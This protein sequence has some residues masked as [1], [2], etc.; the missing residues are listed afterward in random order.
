MIVYDTVFPL[1]GGGLG[2][3]ENKTGERLLPGDVI[4][5]ALQEN[6][7]EAHSVMSR[8]HPRLFAQI[9]RLGA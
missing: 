8:S 6:K 9:N 7:N 2:N 3:T 4:V 1:T 5:C